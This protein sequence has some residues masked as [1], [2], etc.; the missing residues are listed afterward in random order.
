[1][2][3]SALARRLS[4][5]T[6][7]ALPL[8]GGGCYEHVVKESGIGMRSREVYEPN[9]KLPQDDGNDPWGAKKSSSNPGVRNWKS[10]SNQK[11][12]SRSSDDR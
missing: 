5:A 4:L 1:M 2:R 10:I 7:L 3:P 6:L 9:V 8:L 12:Q 11:P